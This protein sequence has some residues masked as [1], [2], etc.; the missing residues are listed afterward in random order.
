MA[1]GAGVTVVE[2]CM[3]SSPIV[4]SGRHSHR[5]PHRGH[6][7]QCGHIAIAVRSCCKSRL[8]ALPSAADSSPVCEGFCVAAWVLCYRSCWC[9]VH[10]GAWC[11][12]DA[13][14]AAS[15]LQRHAHKAAA[16]PSGL[17]GWGAAPGTQDATCCEQHAATAR[18]HRSHCWPL[19]RST[20]NDLSSGTSCIHV[21][22]CG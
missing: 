1:A 11:V 17:A 16:W 4:P 8:H 6:V 15:A 5:C 2:S 12:L 10:H 14:T 7:V 22:S 9:V 19:G 13:V 21:R 18:H 20:I 3:Q